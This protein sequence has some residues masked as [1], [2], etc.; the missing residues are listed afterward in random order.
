M[1]DLCWLRVRCAASRDIPSADV[2]ALLDLYVALE[3]ALRY[4][5]AQA[6]RYAEERRERIASDRLERGRFRDQL[7]ALEVACRGYQERAD[8]AEGQL[9]DAGYH[10]GELRA[11]NAALA[12]TVERVRA[13][14]EPCDCGSG[15]AHCG[16]CE[17][18][19]YPCATIRALD[20]DRDE[21]RR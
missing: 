11:E 15:N 19:S 7:A 20:D 16:T 21:A 1:T 6:Q 5:E 18:L 9:F 8:R 12:A 13:L 10:E 2:I 14:H 17:R 3:S 4:R